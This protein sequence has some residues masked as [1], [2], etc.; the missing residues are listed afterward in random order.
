MKNYTKGLETDRRNRIQS[1]KIEE[2]I[3]VREA[4]NKEINLAIIDLEAGQTHNALTRLRKI[5][6][7]K[8]KVSDNYTLWQGA[9]NAYPQGDWD[10][11]SEKVFCRG[12]EGEDYSIHCVGWVEE[13]SEPLYD[14]CMT[15]GV[16]VNLSER[17]VYRLLRHYSSID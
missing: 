4:L 1:G 8:E 16:E 11:D 9:K 2:R 15:G 10:Y 6:E 12:K 13:T 5:T 7:P 17:E 3:R 14:L